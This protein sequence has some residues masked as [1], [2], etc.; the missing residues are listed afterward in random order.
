M[1]PPAREAAAGPRPAPAGAGDPADAARRPAP[2]FEILRH[3]TTAAAEEMGLTLL[4]SARTIYVREVADFAIALVGLDGRPFAYPAR[5]GVSAFV[6]LDILPTLEAVGPLGPGD[7]VLSNLPYAN[8]GLSTHLPDL[9]LVRPC[10]VD[11]RIVAYG[12][13]M[14]HTSDIGGGVPSSISPRFGEIFQEGLQLPPVRLVRGG[15][16]ERDLL[17]VYLANCRSPETNLGD[18]KAMLAALET[19]ARRIAGICGAHGADRLVAFQTEIADYAAAKAEAILSGLPDGSWEFWDYLDHD[20]VSNLPVRLRVRLTVQG[21]RV[22]LDF[23]GTDPQLM[24]AYNLPTAGLRHPYL[25]LRFLQI[26]MARDKTAPMNHGLIRAVSARAPAGSLLNPAYPAACGVRHATV[27]RLLDTVSGALHQADPGL[28]P[29]AGGGTVLPVVLAETDPATGRRRSMV[30]QSIICGGGGRLGA[31]GIDGRESGLSNVRNAPIEVTEDAAAVRVER[32]ALRPDSGGPGRWRGGLGLIYTLRILAE[33][34]AILARGLE[35]FRFCP[36]G[37]AG[38]SAAP[39]ARVVLNAGT[40]RAREITR[41]D[42][43]PLERGDTITFMTPGGGGYGDPFERPPEA[44]ARDVAAGWVSPASARTDYGVACD[45][46]GLVDAAATEA[47]R[48]APRQRP[49]G[50][51]FGPARRL[52]EAVFDDAT[53]QRLNAALAHLPPG[54]RSARRRRLIEA[55]LPALADEAVLALDA[56]LAE[57]EAARAALA[58]LIAEAEGAAA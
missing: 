33:D 47:L 7:V 31:D 20:F 56:A 21:G 6:D 43:L 18:V 27:L 36:W 44:V 37:V 46:A 35:R 39:P 14:A 5:L 54:D 30:I 11:G 32:Y 8:G 53:V 9:Q 17:A 49:S 13:A 55:A 48:A 51:D 26:A 1:R 4:R 19:G 12:Y 41:L 16:I 3:K 29:A 10:F 2:D 50:F 24:S 57:P 40:A 52:W 15:E 58:R 34:R 38:G 25:T 28:V 42:M 22:D 45:A 23:A